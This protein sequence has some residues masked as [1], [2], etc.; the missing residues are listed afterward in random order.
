MRAHAVIVFT[1]RRQLSI[2]GIVR[3]C[4]GTHA[5]LKFG[6]PYHMSLRSE[7]YGY[8]ASGEQAAGEYLLRGPA[9][10]T[11]EM[12]MMS[13]RATN[14]EIAYVLRDL[15]TWRSKSE[16]ERLSIMQDRWGALAEVVTDAVCATLDLIT[17][18][19]DWQL[20][21]DS[22][23]VQSDTAPMN[24]EQL[25]HLKTW[26]KEQMQQQQSDKGES[27]ENGETLPL[28]TGDPRPKKSREMDA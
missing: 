5:A 1:I 24:E 27:A 6:S 10:D 7:I 8:V 17:P 4:R 13:R 21:L 26:L 3:S 16:F 28:S 23:R 11:L 2:E 18:N 22:P 25:L 14:E 9:D 19:T 15:P 12:L 20:D